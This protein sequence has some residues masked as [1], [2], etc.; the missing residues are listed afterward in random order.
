MIYLFGL[1]VGFFLLLLIVLKKNKTRPDHLLLAWISLIVIHLFLF[2]LHHRGITNDYPHLLGTTLAVPI[3]HGVFLYFY[4]LELTGRSILNV[5]SALLHAIPFLLLTALAIPF[6]LLSGAEKIIVFKNEGRGYEW[7]GV[8][9]MVSFLIS[10]FTYSVLS[11]AH[12]R[13]YQRNIL[14]AFSNTDKRKLKWLEN[15]SIG[16]ALIWFVSAFFPDDVVFAGVVFFVLFI[17]FFGIHQYPVFYAQHQEPAIPL[18]SVN[19]EPP[20]VKESPPEEKYLKSGLHEDDVH[21]VMHVLE[22]V[23]RKQE[24]FRNPNLTLNELAG[25]LKISP[26]HLSQAINTQSGKTFYHYIN[27]YRIEEFIRVS[28]LPGNRKYTYLGLAYQCGFSSK[29]TFNK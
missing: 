1:S 28:S 25:S 4:T 3:L 6:Y 27:S 17:G 20:S 21:Q 22:S 23:M 19:E 26:N 2:V 16:L 8:V 24:P 15:L 29:T 13:R 12:I 9:Q 18:A 5:R 11:I 10:G 14:N 7:Y